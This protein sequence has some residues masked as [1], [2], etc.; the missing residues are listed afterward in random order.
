MN[1]PLILSLVIAS[2]LAGGIVTAI[3]YY[4]PFMIAGSILMAIGGGLLS[5]FETDTGHAK[6]I[7]YQVLFGTGVGM[8]MQQPLMAVQ[9]VLNIADIPI[10]TS[11]VIFSQTLG[12]ALFISIGQNV[13]TNRLISGLVEVV[14]N[15]DPRIVLQTGATSLKHVVD[16][17]YLSGV[18]FAYNRAIDQ[19]FYVVTA[20]GC[21]TLIGSLG[22]EWK[23]VKGKK[24]EVAAA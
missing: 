1:L 15:L 23:S 22:I 6:W 9:T 12:A 7:G 11:A 13:L 20:M 10:G 17:K 16:P 8:G 5:T 21:L 14:P 24:T 4:K 2:V 18:V 19:T 3:G